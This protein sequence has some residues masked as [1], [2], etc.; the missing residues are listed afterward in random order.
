MPVPKS[1]PADTIEARL[2]R[3]VTAWCARKGI[4]E[5]AFGVAALRD[6]DF[7]ASLRRGRSPRLATVDRVLSFIGEVPVG[8]AFY[9]EVEAFLAVTGIKQSLLGKEATGNPSF[10]AHLRG[11]VSPTLTTVQRV[12]AW[13]EAHAGAEELWETRNRMGESPPILAGKSMIEFSMP[14][15]RSSRSV[16]NG[17]ETFH[18]E[19]VLSFEAAA[20]GVNEPGAGGFGK[21]TD[22]LHGEVSVVAVC[23][24]GSHSLPRTSGRRSA[25]GQ[26][27]S[28]GGAAARC[29]RTRLFGVV[30]ATGI[31]V[32]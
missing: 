11:G 23:R 12:R 4:T 19:A 25:H 28:F 5:R 22:R 9:A 1:K 18:D 17:P 32:D 16:A 15:K 8:A 26:A 29:G 13:M 27:R 21:C 2:G 3:A 24:N 14:R 6:P 7:A 10:V 30:T 20:E 31:P